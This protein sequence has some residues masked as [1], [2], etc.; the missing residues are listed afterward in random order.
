MQYIEPIQCY[1]PLTA[2][3]SVTLA[4]FLLLGRHK[5]QILYTGRIITK[6]HPIYII[7]V[8]FTAISSLAIAIPVPF[9]V[10]SHDVGNLQQRC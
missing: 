5:I 2:Y 9:N 6:M 8:A 1:L 3:D 7:I 10:V 4:S